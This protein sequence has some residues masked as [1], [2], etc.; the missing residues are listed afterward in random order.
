MCEV[1]LT[2]R[3]LFSGKN[4]TWNNEVGLE[5]VN[6]LN[7]QLGV[8]VCFAPEVRDVCVGDLNNLHSRTAFLVREH[9]MLFHVFVTLRN[10]GFLTFSRRQRGGERKQEFGRRDFSGA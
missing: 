10:E 9:E 4:Y 2:L 5:A 8:L 1:A 3:S 7:R 6:D